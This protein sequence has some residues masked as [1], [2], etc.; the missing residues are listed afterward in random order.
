MA[1]NN[2]VAKREPSPSETFRDQLGRMGGELQAGLP[3]HM[4]VERFMRVVLTAVNENPDLLLADR[5]SLLASSMRAAQDGLLPDGREGALVVYNTKVPGKGGEKDRWIKKVQWMPMVA[6]LLKKARNSGEILSIEAHIVYSKDR[7]LYVL[8]DNPRIEH[9]PNLEADD[10]G[11]PR[12]AYA[13]AWLKNGGVIREVMTRRQIDQ[14]KAASKNADPDKPNAVWNKWRDEMWR[15]SAF[16]RLFKW[17]PKSAEMD[18]LIRR[19]DEENGLEDRAGLAAAKAG[20]FQPVARPLDDDDHADT[21]DIPEAGEE[22]FKRAKLA[23][24]DE[25]RVDPDTGE[26]EEIRQEPG[27]APQKP[28]GAPSERGQQD[29]GKSETRAGEAESQ[30]AGPSDDD[31]DEYGRTAADRAKAEAGAAELLTRG[32]TA[33]QGQ[34]REIPG[35]KSVKGGPGGENRTESIREY[36]AA[37]L[38]AA[39]KRGATGRRNGM[40][41]SAV[42]KEFKEPGSEPLRDAWIDGWDEE[43]QRQKEAEAEKDRLGGI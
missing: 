5:R 42:P 6:G 25:G 4:S 17:L 12:F 23:G 19:D 8:G 16:R 15:K 28:A 43:V 36:D 24:S 20:L 37:D 33:K 31:V 29:S 7:F 35:E 26:I 13:I 21:S 1:E 9:E 18:D 3:P 38:A 14:V 30:G 11:E 2:S 40:P 39:K 27:K 32:A 22:W 10:P 41:R 34:R